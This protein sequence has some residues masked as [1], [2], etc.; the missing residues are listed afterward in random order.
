MAQAAG[1]EQDV[2]GPHRERNELCLL[3]LQVGVVVNAVWRKRK[4][5]PG[6]NRRANAAGEPPHEKRSADA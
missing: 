5:D 4:D 2:K 6:E 1:I 3:Q